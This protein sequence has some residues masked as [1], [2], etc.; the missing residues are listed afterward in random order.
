MKAAKDILSN[1]KKELKEELRREIIEELRELDT[2]IKA[3]SMSRRVSQRNLRS[4]A[5]AHDEDD[6]ESTSKEGSIRGLSPCVSHFRRSFSLTEDEVEGDLKQIADEWHEAA[7]DFRKTQNFIPVTVESGKMQYDDL[8]FERGDYVLIQSEFTK[9][10]ALGHLVAVR[11]KEIHV[12]T[13]T[14]KKW[15]IQVEHLRTGRVFLFPGN[16]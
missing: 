15:Q 3:E 10:Q 6:G 5:K 2:S 4:K 14:G 7:V 11:K 1:S 8:H 16:M 13:R 12:K 9:M